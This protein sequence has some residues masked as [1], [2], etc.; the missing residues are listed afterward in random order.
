MRGGK[1]LKDRKKVF[2]A[3]VPAA[4]GT[5]LVV[6]KVFFANAASAAPFC[7]VHPEPDD[8]LSLPVE[9]IHSQPIYLIENNPAKRRMIYI[10]L[11]FKSIKFAAK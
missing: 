6:C 1:I 5:H 2:S 8:L 10:S 4:F 11:P 7:F 3:G 9:I